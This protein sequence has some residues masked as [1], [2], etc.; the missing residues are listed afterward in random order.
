[1]VRAVVPIG[2]DAPHVTAEDQYRH[3][4]EHSHHFEPQSVADAGEGAQKTGETAD[5]AAA[6]AASRLAGGTAGRA[7]GRNRL[8][9]LK[10]AACLRLGGNALAGYAARYTQTDAEGAAYGLGSH[11]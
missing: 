10:L 8:R 1:M 5:Q 4:K 11:P 9:R 6:G 3:Q 2:A 7:G